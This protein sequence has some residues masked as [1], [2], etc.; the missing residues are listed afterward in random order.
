M[1][2]EE[3]AIGNNLTGVEATLVVSV[4]VVPIPILQFDHAP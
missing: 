3:T 2:L 1:K 4:A